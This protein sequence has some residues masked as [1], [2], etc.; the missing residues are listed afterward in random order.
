VLAAVLTAFVGHSVFHVEPSVVALLGAGVLV[1]VSGL[2][3]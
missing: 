1:L 2:R 3:P